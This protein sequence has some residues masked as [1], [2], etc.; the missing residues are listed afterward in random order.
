[1]TNK[2][3]INYLVKTNESKFQIL[4]ACEELS[5]LNTILLQDITKEGRKTIQQDIIDEIGDVIIR[6]KI[7]KKIYGK[8]KVNKRINLKLQ[9][10]KKYIINN[11][12]KH[13]I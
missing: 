3:I 1:M 10:F 11:E 12:Y 8:K 9:E 5:E 13:N 6:M 4:K 2:E 7:L